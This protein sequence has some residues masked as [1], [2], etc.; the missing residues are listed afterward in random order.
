MLGVHCEGVAGY[1]RFLLVNSFQPLDDGASTWYAHLRSRYLTKSSVHVRAVHTSA[2]SSPVRSFFSS[3][4]VLPGTPQYRT[5][6]DRT[7]ITDPMEMHP[8]LCPDL[9]VFEVVWRTHLHAE[10]R[11]KDRPRYPCICDTSS[12]FPDR[13]G[14]GLHIKAR[15][16]I[17]PHSALR[18]QPHPTPP[19]TIP[20]SFSFAPPHQTTPDSLSWYLGVVGEA[21]SE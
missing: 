5:Y 8:A 12:K 17:G 7:F 16:V 10:R 14:Y 6:S 18:T 1:H 20:F 19:P 15:N 9:D 13:D 11:P 3:Y 2:E 4:S 21:G